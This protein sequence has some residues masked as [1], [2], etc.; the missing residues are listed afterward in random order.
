MDEKSD[1]ISWTIRRKDYSKAFL[2][3]LSNQQ[4][5]W[6]LKNIRSLRSVVYPM[7]MI[8]GMKTP[9]VFQDLSHF[10]LVDPEFLASYWLRTGV[11]HLL[12]ISSKIRRGVYHISML[13][14]NTSGEQH[15][16]EG[17]LLITNCT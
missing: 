17:V 11:G 2:K 7:V 8:V 9:Y 14:D 3:L 4:E 13:L 12:Y 5:T 16:I 15:L 1:P 6:H 10:V